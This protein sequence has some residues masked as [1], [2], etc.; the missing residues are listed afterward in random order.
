M[1]VEVGFFALKPKWP[2]QGCLF[3][4]ALRPRE[5]KRQPAVG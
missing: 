3:W 5:R 4:R 2:L 1:S